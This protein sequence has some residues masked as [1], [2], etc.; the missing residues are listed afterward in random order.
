MSGQ[1]IRE[2]HSCGLEWPDPER[3]AIGTQWRCDCGNEFQI[4]YAAQ[5]VPTKWWY[6]INVPPIVISDSP[7][8]W[9]RFKAQLKGGTK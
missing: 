7:S 2:V 4:S 9:Q 8:R 6:R 5:R 1:I 3:Y